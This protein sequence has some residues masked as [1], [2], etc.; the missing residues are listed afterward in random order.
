VFDDYDLGSK[1]QK[2]TVATRYGSRRELTRCVAMMR[3]N[4]LDVYADLV[5]NQRGGG[6]GPGGFAFRYADADG[7]VGGGRFSKDPDD[8]HPNVPQDPNVPGPDFSFGTDLAPINGGPPGSL[9]ERL[10]DSADWLTRS[11]DLQ[12]YRI[13]DAKGQSS[14]FLLRFLRP[15]T[16]VLAKGE[17]GKSVDAVVA[18]TGFHAFVIQASHTPATNRKPRYALSVSYQ[19]PRT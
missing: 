19:A 10:I 6:N 1:N 2:G 14:D 11:L 3:A 12:G 18:A 4:G 13:D 7:A 8:F 5:E 9:A 17:Q 16:R 15:G